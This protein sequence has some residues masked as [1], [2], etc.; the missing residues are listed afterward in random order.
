VPKICVPQN[1]LVQVR[2]GEDGAVQVGAVEVSSEEMCFWKEDAA[3][4][5]SAKIK[6][7]RFGC[8]LAT[9]K[10]RKS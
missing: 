5:G 6:E 3:Q 9:P 4:V 1:G 7:V 8:K 2:F 10:D